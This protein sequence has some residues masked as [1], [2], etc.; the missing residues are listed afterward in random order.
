MKAAEWRRR[1]E[2]R[3]KRHRVSAHRALKARRR[4]FKELRKWYA[5]PTLDDWVA[6]VI[7]GKV[8]TDGSTLSPDWICGVE[9]GRTEENPDYPPLPAALHDQ[10]FSE[11]GG[12]GM[13]RLANR[14]FRDYLR[15]YVLELRDPEAWTEANVRRRVALY[16]WGVNTRLAMRH[17]HWTRV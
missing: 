16:A 12:L 1:R 6:L 4:A 2:L 7:A 14:I 9:I 13:F 15:I 3:R 11:G 5:L 17:F 10:M 8:A